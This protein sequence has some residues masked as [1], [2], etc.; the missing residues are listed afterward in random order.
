[1]AEAL[2]REEEV[3][4]DSEETFEVGETVVIRDDFHSPY[5]RGMHATIAGPARKAGPAKPVWPLKLEKPPFEIAMHG[6][7]LVRKAEW[8]AGKAGSSSNRASGSLLG[9]LL[10]WKR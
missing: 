7:Y 1:M 3:E 4:A 9:R 10:P 8:E 6:K 5:Y 2:K